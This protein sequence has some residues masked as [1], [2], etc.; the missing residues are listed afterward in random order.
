MMTSTN[1]G[2]VNQARPLPIPEGQSGKLDPVSLI[3]SSRTLTHSSH[4]SNQATAS[5]QHPS[6]CQLPVDPYLKSQ[7]TLKLSPNHLQTPTQHP[8]VFPWKRRKRR[9]VEG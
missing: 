8:L 7:P 9:E 2:Q 4:A 1:T 5:D 3:S 6:Q